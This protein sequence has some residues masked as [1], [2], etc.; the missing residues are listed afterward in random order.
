MST[1]AETVKP[2]LS[3]GQREKRRRQQ[4]RYR[5]T[6]RKQLYVALAS[7]PIAAWDAVQRAAVAA[8]V[9][10]QVYLVMVMEKGLVALGIHPSEETPMRPVPRDVAGRTV[11]RTLIGEAQG[12]GDPGA[13][14]MEGIR[15]AAATLGGPGALT[16]NY[17]EG[18]LE[19]RMVAV[20]AMGW[21]EVPNVEIGRIDAPHAPGASDTP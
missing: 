14:L 10:L 8:G 17:A 20:L 6:H 12:G 7:I 16:P 9:P 13:V 1:P 5:A 4:R 15:Y 3:P 21:E 18:S 11:A 19:A 2:R